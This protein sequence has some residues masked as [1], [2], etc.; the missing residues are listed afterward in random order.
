M[1]AALA[2]QQE[3]SLQQTRRAQKSPV[4]RPN[5]LPAA[6]FDAIESAVVNAVR[7]D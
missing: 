2:E 5:L 4:P 3:P 7:A 1:Q 6:I